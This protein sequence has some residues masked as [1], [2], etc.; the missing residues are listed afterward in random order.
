MKMEAVVFKN[1]KILRKTPFSGMFKA[2]VKSAHTH[3]KTETV[4]KQV[5]EAKRTSQ[6]KSVVF[7]KT[8]IRTLGGLNITKMHKHNTIPTTDMKRETAEQTATHKLIM[9]TKK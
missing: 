8:E 6:A 3:S 2:I 5:M 4:S 9:T 1:K 7:F